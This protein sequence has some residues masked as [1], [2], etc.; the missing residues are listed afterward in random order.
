MG[1]LGCQDPNPREESLSSEVPT[2]SGENFAVRFDGTND[3]ATMGTARFAMPTLPQ[4]ISL[5]LKLG[6]KGTRQA[7]LTLRRDD[8]GNVLGISET[9][10]VTLYRIWNPSVLV[11]ASAPLDVES[12]HHLAYVHSDG[13]H[14]LYV[15]GVLKGS[16][17]ASPDNRSPT[18]GWLGTFD[19]QS[20]LFRGELDELRVW[21]IARTALDITSEFKE[22]G[23]VSDPELVGYYSFNESR[24]ARVYDRSGN[25]NHLTLG[26]G[27][28]EYMPQRVI[29]SRP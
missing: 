10:V 20:Q 1:L 9:G 2:E 27:V 21:S 26:D 12:W 6:S 16:S 14:F 22:G 29:A 13:Q 17:T 11:E 18:S 28:T 4:C 8:S 23:A 24:G 5:W 7:L 3:Y 15:D 25:G 19:G